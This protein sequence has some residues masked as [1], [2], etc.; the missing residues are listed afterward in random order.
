MEGQ[1]KYNLSVHRHKEEITKQPACMTA[2]ELRDYQV[3]YA[4]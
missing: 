4:A 1:A 3:L 2:G